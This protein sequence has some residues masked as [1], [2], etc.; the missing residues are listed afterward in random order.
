MIKHP[1]DE[2]ANFHR[3]DHVSILLK[4]CLQPGK[5]LLKDYIKILK[6]S[7]LFYFNIAM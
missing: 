3:D 5:H 1:S 6:H 4:N 7:K 2:L